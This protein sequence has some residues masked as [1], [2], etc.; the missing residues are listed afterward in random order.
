M[1]NNKVKILIAEDDLNFGFL[2][3]EFLESSG[4]ETKLTRD[5]ESALKAFN[6]Q[7][8]NICLLDVMMPN[9]DGFTLATQIRAINKSVPII[10]ITAKS[11]KDDKLKG[12][13]IGADDYIT[14]PFDE[15]ELVCRINAILKRSNATPI[16]KKKI[17]NIGKY[18]FDFQNQALIFEGQSKRITE[19]ECEVLLYLCSNKNI[20]VKRADLLKAVWGEDDYFLGRS[21]DVFI[22][23][24]RKYIK[25][26]PSISIDNVHNVGFIFNCR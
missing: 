4:F 19:K 1:E 17:L 13:E 15:D 6:N 20:L 24:I 7:I 10:F 26:D 25:D 8:F 14:K 23:K 18:E 9:K 21:M 3:A 22:S 12:F 11:L 2:I 16:E 5:G